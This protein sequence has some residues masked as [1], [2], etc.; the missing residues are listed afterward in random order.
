MIGTSGSYFLYC[1][2]CFLSI[3]FVVFLVPETKGRS[4]EDMK[5]LF[6]KNKEEKP[7]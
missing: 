6:M 7:V 1:I 5:R 3:P 4:P 2:V